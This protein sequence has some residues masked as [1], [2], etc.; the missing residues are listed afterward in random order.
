MTVT[1]PSPAGTH[2]VH[3]ACPHDCPDA[4][5]M[6][7]T[8]ADG[9]AT[10]VRGDPDHPFTRGSLCTKVNDYEVH[11][12]H[13]DRILYPMRRVGPK[14]A[15]VGPPD[16]GES[17]FERITWDEAVAEICARFRSITDEYGSQAI[18]PVSF[19]GNISLL[20]GMS[21]GDPF[22]HRLGATVAE[23]TMCISTRSTAWLLTNGPAVVDPESIVASRYI[24]IWGSNVLSA[25]QHLWPFIRE[26]RKA[27]AQVVVI[28]P[29]R[30]RTAAQAD[31]FIPIRPGTDGALALGLVHVLVAE[32]LVDHDYVER[33]TVGF[34]D[35]AARGAPW[36]PERVEEATGVPAADVRTLATNLATRQPSMI[37][38]GVAIERGAT[39][40]QAFRTIFSLPALVGAWRH[41]GGGALEMPLWAFPVKWDALAKPEW[42][43][44]GTRVVNQLQLGRALTGQLGLDPPV[45]AAMIYNA[46]PATH[47]PESRL[48]V[49]G[50]A[51]DDLFTVVHELFMTDTARYADIVLPATTVLEHFD[52]TFAW[53]HT[54]FQANN[55]AI[56]PVGEAVSNT[57]LFRRLAA[58][59]GFD[60]EWFSLTDT[61]MAE[62]VIDW[63][64]PAAKGL[65]LEALQRDGWAR[66]NLAPPTDAPYAEGG[67]PT[68]SGKVEIRSSLVEAAGGPFVLPLFREGYTAEVEPRPL[69]PVPDWV[70]PEYDPRFPLTLLTPKA[71]AFLN[72][73]Y[74]SHVRQATI[75]GPPKVM[76]N[77]GDAAYRD[78]RTGDPV[79]VHN[80]TGIFEAEA[81]VRDDVV[82]GTLISIYGYWRTGPR[83]ALNACTPAD[84][85]E[86]GNG[87]S[88]SECRVQLNH[89]R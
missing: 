56:T 19:T 39:G 40:G 20:N 89:A 54:Y 7:V 13:P 44:P 78:I 8:V 24:V 37:N 22:M 4:C 26:A 34:D 1:I 21:C 80:D 75:E 81:T 16:G 50:L 87:P 23:R 76:V 84:L 31:R 43:R 30:T 17:P 85:N 47:L 3:A 86:M 36:T 60:D 41:A 57:E 9:V 73:Q 79:W 25:N 10:G 61:E 27:G 83:T 46:N 58:G 5:S 32:G 35:L 15:R 88:L 71:H 53:G 62:A 11:A 14:G 28:D 68:P 72:S 51:R 49:E 38:V 2:V 52:V 67:F 45:K 42:V 55:P 6:L 12:Y 63:D 29:Y 74:A 33:H 64:A 48:V 65:S 59:M 77:A 69:D 82:A 70:P 66:L 18:L